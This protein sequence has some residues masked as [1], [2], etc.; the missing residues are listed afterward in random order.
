MGNPPETRFLKAVQNHINKGEMQGGLSNHRCP[1]RAKRWPVN[2]GAMQCST[3]T[4]QK[5]M[6]QTVRGEAP[7]RAPATARLASWWLGAPS[8]LT[9]TSNAPKSRQKSPRLSASG[10]EWAA[11]GSNLFSDLYFLG[12]L[13]IRP[14]FGRKQG[15]RGVGRVGLAEIWLCHLDRNWETKG[16]QKTTEITC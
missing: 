5:D 4:T 8:A 6:C 12:F 10:C 13:H 1:Y 2:Q 11:G 16:C 9:A 3:K 15:G 14:C 7:S